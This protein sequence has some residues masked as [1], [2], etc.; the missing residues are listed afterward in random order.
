MIKSSNCLTLA[1]RVPLLWTDLTRA[2][3]L[4]AIPVIPGKVK[5]Y[6]RSFQ[7]NIV[8]NS[9]NRLKLSRCEGGRSWGQRAGKVPNIRDEQ[10]RFFQ[11]REM[12]TPIKF[13]P[14]RNIIGTFGKRS[15]RG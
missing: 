9:S 11:G 10:V 4:V 3:A 8:F 2:A 7:P 5:L 15:R 14:A 12:P 6:A 13:G 1:D